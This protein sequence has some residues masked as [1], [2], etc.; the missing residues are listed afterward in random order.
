FHHSAVNRL[1]HERFTFTADLIEATATVGF[2][3]ILRRLCHENLQSL[4]NSEFAN[5]IFS[6]V[7]P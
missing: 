5:S 6:S 2:M 1:R 7:T 4:K 3:P